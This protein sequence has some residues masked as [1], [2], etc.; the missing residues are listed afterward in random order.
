MFTKCLVHATLLLSQR[1]ILQE[2]KMEAGEHKY[3][4]I[5]LNCILKWLIYIKI[6]Y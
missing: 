1:R 3:I 2:S 6:I 5:I 4:V